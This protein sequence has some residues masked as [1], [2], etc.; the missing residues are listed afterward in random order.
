[1]LILHSV[2]LSA[3][4]MPAIANISLV[5][6]CSWLCGWIIVAGCQ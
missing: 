2:L 4:S 6:Y 5:C 3:A 1:M